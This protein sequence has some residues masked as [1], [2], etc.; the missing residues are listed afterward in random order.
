M[1]DSPLKKGDSFVQGPIIPRGEVCHEAQCEGVSMAGFEGV[2]LAANKTASY[3][4]NSTS[5]CT[6]ESLT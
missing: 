3:R 1:Q 6:T 5:K 4:V 2:G